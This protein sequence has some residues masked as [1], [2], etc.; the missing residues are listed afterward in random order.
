MPEAQR[1]AALIEKEAVVK[2]RGLA[3]KL[4]MWSADRLDRFERHL[5]LQGGG[6][7]LGEG[8]KRM[9]DALKVVEGLLEQPRYLLLMI[10]A[11]LVVIL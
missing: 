6:G 5:V 3:G 8:L 10:M 2:G 9:G 7:K 1:A 4:L 11:T